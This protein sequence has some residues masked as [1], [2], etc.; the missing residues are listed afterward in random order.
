MG[1]AALLIALALQLSWGMDNK[2]FYAHSEK[3]A[4]K[5]GMDRERGP[6]YTFQQV[7]LAAMQW[8]YG[9]SDPIVGLSWWDDSTRTWTIYVLSDKAYDDFADAY[10]F[11]KLT[12]H[13]K[14]KMQDETIVH[15]LV[16]CTGI[17]SEHT[18]TILEGVISQGHQSPTQGFPAKWFKVIKQRAESQ[19]AISP[20]VL[21]EIKKQLEEQQQ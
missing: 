12:T 18:T 9:K 3:W 2:T 16:H 11:P 4:K 8:A 15:E 5:F 20:E 14:H 17:N 6:L 10:K 1:K 7:P 13:E 21:E 19:K